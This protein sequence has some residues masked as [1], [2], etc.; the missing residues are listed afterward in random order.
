MERRIRK[1]LSVR[2]RTYPR[3]ENT[4]TR[5]KKEEEEE[6][7]ATPF[8]PGTRKVSMGFQYA[9]HSERQERLVRHFI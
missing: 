3:A 9:I 1:F 7:A 5:T 4:D 8:P 6:E 2:T